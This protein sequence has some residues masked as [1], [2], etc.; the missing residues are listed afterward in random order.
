MGKTSSEKIKELKEALWHR[1][2]AFSIMFDLL[3][4]DYYP[5]DVKLRIIKVVVDEICWQELNTLESIIY[6]MYYHRML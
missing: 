4:S 6:D 1:D 5:D 2:T 3:R